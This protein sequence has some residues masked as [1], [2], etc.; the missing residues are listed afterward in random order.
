MGTLSGSMTFDYGGKTVSIVFDPNK[1]MIDNNLSAGDKAKALGDMI[2]EKLEMVLL[3]PSR[4]MFIALPEIRLANADA[5]AAMVNDEIQKEFGQKITVSNVG[6][7][8]EKGVK[9]LQLKVSLL[10]KV[11][12]RVV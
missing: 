7:A 1:D 9:S 3:L 6:T 2:R 4:E 5:Y 12:A 8:D 10:V 11:N